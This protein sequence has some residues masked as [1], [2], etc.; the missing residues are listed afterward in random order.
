VNIR[1]SPEA[2]NDLEQIAAFI[3]N[4]KPSAAHDVINLIYQRIA[5]LSTFP[6]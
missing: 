6:N 4:D 3:A 2:A 5:D 1:W